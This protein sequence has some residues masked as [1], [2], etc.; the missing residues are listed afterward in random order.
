[1]FSHGLRGEASQFRFFKN[2]LKIAVPSCKMLSCISNEENSEEDIMT[3][4]KRLADE[5]LSYLDFCQEEDPSFMLGR[6]SFI[7]HSLGG[8]II[9]AGLPHL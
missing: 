4:G 7:A 8:L 1:M 6:I 2:I 5:V 3:M 9:R